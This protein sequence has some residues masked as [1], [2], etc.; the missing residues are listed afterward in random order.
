MS[1][2]LS[3]I[4]ATLLAIQASAPAARPSPVFRYQ[5]NRAFLLGLGELDS[6]TQDVALET[7]DWTVR[8]WVACGDFFIRRDGGRAV[9]G[10]ITFRAQ[11]EGQ[12]PLRS[13]A[14]DRAGN[15]QRKGSG[16]D[17]ADVV[18]VYDATPPAIDVVAPERAVVVEPDGNCLL[19]WRTRDANPAKEAAASIE[20]TWDRGRTW[21]QMGGRF[22]DDGRFRLRVPDRQ[23]RAVVRLTVWDKCGNRGDALFPELIVRAARTARAGERDAATG[24]ETG[25]AVSASGTPPVA[26]AKAVARAKEYYRR[27]AAA[28][29]SDRHAKAVGLLRKATDENPELRDAWLDL[30]VALAKAGNLKGSREAL[31][32]AER[33]FPRYADFP[34]NRGR[35]LMD[36]R[37]PAEAKAAFRRACHLDPTHVEAHWL[38]ARLSIDTGDLATARACW[39]VVVKYAPPGSKTGARARKYLEA[40]RP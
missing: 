2:R 23:G 25:T 14:R 29:V 21:H 4:A 15:V 26:D 34:Y 8:G 6:D 19:A 27:G 5:N 40:S 12:Y 32:S 16:P 35:V 9:D 18:A 30:S 17:A 11:R 28:L 37:Q 7:Y 31:L 20:L 10:G 33:R 24:A 22:D 36:M 38:L 1:L 39:R 3:I 13:I